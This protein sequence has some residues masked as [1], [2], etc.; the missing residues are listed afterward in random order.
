MMAKRGKKLRKTASR[1]LGPRDPR[2]FRG[3]RKRPA[4]LRLAAPS[5]PLSTASKR[6]CALA[7]PARSCAA[8]GPRHP[9]ALKLIEHGFPRLARRPHATRHVHFQKVLGLSHIAKPNA[10]ATYNND[11]PMELD[12]TLTTLQLTLYSKIVEK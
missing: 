7:M 8:T 12:V 9:A 10:H 3:A 1:L 6:I 2:I 11:Y 4:H 5:S